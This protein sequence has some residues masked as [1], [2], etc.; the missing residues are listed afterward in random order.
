MTQFLRRDERGA[1]LVLTLLAASILM[2]LGLVLVFLSFVERTTSRQVFQERQAFFLADVESAYLT[3]GRSVIA[4]FDNWS[5]AL[6]GSSMTGGP[7]VTP[8]CSR[9]HL[10]TDPCADQVPTTVDDLKGPWCKGLV[11]RRPPRATSWD[12]TDP[13]QNPFRIRCMQADRFCG[14]RVLLPDGHTL[15]DQQMTLYVRNDIQDTD[16]LTDNNGEITLIAVTET[17]GTQVVL[18]FDLTA[19]TQGGL[20]YNIWQTGAREE[21]PSGTP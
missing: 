10:Q 1:A 16:V 4:M 5:E 15:S 11:L 6:G 20:G 13:N 2:G 18:A 3:I 19:W 7:T 17:F 12:L 8:N 9:T 21:A 14:C